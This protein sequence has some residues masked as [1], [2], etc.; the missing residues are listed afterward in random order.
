MLVLGR[1]EDQSILLR[2]EP[3]REPQ[4]IEVKVVQ[5]RAGSVRIGIEADRE[6]VAI[7]REE[8]VVE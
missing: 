1:K 5:V 6:A 8:L 7:L 2:V 4:V 3:S